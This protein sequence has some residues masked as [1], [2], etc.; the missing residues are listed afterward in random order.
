MN[1][2]EEALAKGLPALNEYDAK[3][4]LAGFGIPV[5][6][7]TLVSD[8][9]KAATEAANI[10]FPVVLKASGATLFHKTEVGGIALN[11]KSREEVRN[12]AHRLLRIPGS[13]AVLVQEMIKGDRELVC[14]LT[15][16]AQLGPCVMFG[17]GGILTEALDD[18]VFRLAPL[19][20]ADALE[21]MQEIRSARILGPFR[22][23]PPADRAALSRILMALGTIAMQYEAIREVDLNPVKIRADGSPVAVDALI[24]LRTKEP[25][26][27]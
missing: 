22:G 17:L 12:E 20:S 9:E 14:G 21:M 4:F 19:T 13:Q 10:G 27:H 15:R 25:S 24:S 7:E 16:D 3:R 26:R 23:Q 18:A 5:C 8:P 11:L 2:V 6:H 1:P